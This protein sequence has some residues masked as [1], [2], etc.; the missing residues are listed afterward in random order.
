[1]RT[2]TSTLAA[3]KTD[4][5]DDRSFGVTLDELSLHSYVQP[6]ERSGVAINSWGGWF[7]AS[8]ADGMI[9]TFLTLKNYQRAVVG[10]WNHGG[11]QNASPYQTAA[12][13]RVMQVLEW[14]RFF[15]HYLKDVDTGIDADRQF[16]Y[17]TIGEEKWKVTNRWPVA[18][19]EMTRWYCDENNTLSPKGAWKAGQDSYTINFE[20][21]TG[22]RIVGTHRVG[23]GQVVY[24]D[25]ADEDKKLLTY[26]SNP[27]ESDVEV[28]GYPIV[29]SLRH[30]NSY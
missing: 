19:T 8:T 28:T 26:T 17:F 18:G 15:D 6:L 1:M 30:L 24:G 21:T 11:S 7:D 14:L 10:P 13:Q 12:S 2:W 9:K 4:F 3:R 25:R 16:Y 27:L 23:G 5:R 29:R 22:Q 20:A